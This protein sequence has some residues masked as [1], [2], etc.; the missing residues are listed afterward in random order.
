[1][2]PWLRPEKKGFNSH[3]WERGRVAKA[4]YGIKNHGRD[5]RK[6]EVNSHC[7]NRGRGA[8]TGYDKNM[9][10]G[11]IKVTV[12]SMYALLQVSCRVKWLLK[13]C[14]CQTASKMHF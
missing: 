8:G 6:R 4:G 7:W 5:L 10:K 14:L 13:S 12:W 11:R 1:M 9:G 3:C 2:Q